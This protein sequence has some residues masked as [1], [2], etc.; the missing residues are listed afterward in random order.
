MLKKIIWL[1]YVVSSQVIAQNFIGCNKGLDNYV[2]GLYNDSVLNKLVVFGQFDYADGKLVRGMATWDGSNFDSLGA[3]DK[4]GLG[5]HPE[6]I[7]RY[8]NKLY[9]QFQ[10]YFL[11]SYDYS[12]KQWQKIPNKFGGWIWD[13]TILNNELYIVGDFDSV[14]T[15]KVKNIIKFNGTNFDTLF[16]RPAFSYYLT[17]I[18]A[19]KNEIYVG[20]LFDP[21][22]FQGVAKYDGTGWVSASP[23]FALTGSAEVR[24]FEIYNGKLFM[25]GQWS[26]IDGKYS[27][28]FSSWDGQ[29]WSNLGGL[30][31]NGGTPAA[32][33]LLKVYKNKL[34]VIGGFDNA[35]SIKTHNIAVWNDTS[36]CG[37]KMITNIGLQNVPVENYQNQW[38]F[39][40]GFIMSGDTVPLSAN[41]VEDTVNYLGRYLGNNGKLERDCYDRPA[42][43]NAVVNGLFPN[44]TSDIINFNLANNLGEKCDLKIINNLGQIISDYQGI[45]SDSKIDIETFASGVYV[46]LFRNNTNQKTFKVV[47]H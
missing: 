44:P 13:A 32:I 31:F 7:I 2:W 26:A 24:D 38:Y 11:H 10:D 40:G 6:M 8:Q 12:T 3:G 42:K 23:N 34:Y 29:L 15:I 9:V 36:W 1:F 39:V 18:A 28:S 43:E 4:K 14:G 33:S 46:F 25:C 5:G 30:T 47:K 35:D 22:P 37:V 19:F 45:R 20:G 21:L 41:S 16:I 17:C 27:P